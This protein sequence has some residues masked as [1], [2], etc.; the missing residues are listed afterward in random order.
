MK[1]GALCLMVA[2]GLLF[3]PG[4]GLAKGDN[5]RK[6]ELTKKMVRM[7][8]PTLDM[9]YRQLERVVKLKCTKPG[10]MDRIKAA[11]E[12]FID[13]I[14][15]V[16]AR[17]LT[18]AQLKEMLAF[19]Q[20]PVGRKLIGMQLIIVKEMQGAIMKMMM[21]RQ[22]GKSMASL[23]DAISLKSLDP[24]RLA[25]ARELTKLVQFG[26]IISKTSSGRLL[27]RQGITAVMLEEFWARLNAKHFNLSEM[28]QLKVFYQSKAYQD[29][30][31]A[32]PRISAKVERMTPEFQ[33]KL[34][35][36]LSTCK[37]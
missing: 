24:Q 35:G 23:A 9:A 5:A 28:N 16:T 26:K 25:V 12:G 21:A 19:Y 6:L 1:R 29:Y 8:Q 17:E 14:T 36:I 2:V 37:Q 4:G 32:S 7:A 30:V 11:F 34:V 31:T 3:L 18:L 10:T 13:R 33:K 15:E 22:Q 20:T 27:E